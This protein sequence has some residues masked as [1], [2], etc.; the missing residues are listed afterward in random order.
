[1][2]ENKKENLNIVRGRVMIAAPSS[3]SGKT[4]I[5]IGLIESLKRKGH[6]AISYKCGPDYIDP[7]FHKEVLGIPS[8]NLDTWFYDK[9][10]IEG[11]LARAP[12]ETDISIME[13]VM[14]LY[15]GLGG[16]R[17]EGSAYHLAELTDTPIVLVIDAGHMGRTV[18]ALLM[19]LLSY[20]RSQL[21][22]GVI[23]NHTGKTMYETLAPLIREELG[24]EALGYLPKLKELHIESRHLGLKLPGEI[25]DLHQQIAKLADT[26]SE[27]VDLE[28]ILKIAGA[29]AG[30]LAL[31]GSAQNKAGLRL[32]VAQDEAFCFYYEENFRLLRERGVEIVPFSPLH[33]K[34]LP[35]NIDGLLIGGGY[36]ELY[37]EQLAENASMRTAI[38]HALESGLPSL[39]ECGGFMYLHD[40]IR[41]HV[42]GAAE[43]TEYPMVGVVAGSCY[44]TGK[45][46]R[47]GYVELQAEN[48]G[49]VI[50]GHEFH[51]YESSNQ[52]E[53][54]TALKPVSGKQWKTG[55]MTEKSLWGFPHLYYGSCPQFVDRFVEAMKKEHENRENR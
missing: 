3:G 53:D 10:G 48:N 27:T 7:M 40:T 30:S 24:I 12:K 14:G 37:P 54:L 23:L 33:D 21:I 2:T 8:E 50:R 55:F 18:I 34:R 35:E 43:E 17:E 52:G 9:K 19:G 25:D 13:G 16:T 4:V 49:P 39:A 26:R 6:K 42:L 29:A 38:R 45:L 5:T 32:A 51:Y 22:K 41:V 46:N 1:M 36:P 11:I 31:A 28:G 20:D 44:N 47:F 15:D